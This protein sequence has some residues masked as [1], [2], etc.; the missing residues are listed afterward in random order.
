MD[1]TRNAAAHEQERHYKKDKEKYDTFH[2]E[3]S[4]QP[5]QADQVKGARKF[6]AIIKKTPKCVHKLVSELTGGITKYSTG[7][8]RSNEGKIIKG[9]EDT[10]ERWKEHIKELY[11]AERSQLIS[12][13]NNCDGSSMLQEEVLDGINHVKREESTGP[14]KIFI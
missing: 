7:I 6:K 14:E 9:K 1:D 4:K 3:I 2:E 10:V 5:K 13:I 11:D 12:N 8:F